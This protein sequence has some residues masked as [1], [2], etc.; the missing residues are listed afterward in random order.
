MRQGERETGRQGD[1][2][3]GREGERERDR[4]KDE[5]P[6]G[7]TTWYKGTGKKRPTRLLPESG[8]LLRVLCPNP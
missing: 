1:R 6:E 3:T 5:R 4:E 8:V 2:E 7:D